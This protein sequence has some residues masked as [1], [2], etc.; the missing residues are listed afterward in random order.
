[1]RVAGQKALSD[2]RV[3]AIR[4]MANTPDGVDYKRLKNGPKSVRR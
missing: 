2:V 1:L 4:M 3:A